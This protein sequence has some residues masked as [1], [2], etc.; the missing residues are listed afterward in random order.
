MTAAKDPRPFLAHIAESIE[1]IERHVAGM[2]I[3][4]FTENVPAQDMVARRLEIIGEAA[5]NIPQEFREQHSSLAWS[6]M[7]GMRNVL[8]HQYFGIDPNIVWDTVVRDLPKLKKQI[9]QLR[10]ELDADRGVRAV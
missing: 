7:V 4:D 8:I 10:A 9:A 1:W 5:R 6:N 3:E 2:G